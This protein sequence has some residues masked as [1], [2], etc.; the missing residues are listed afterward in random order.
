MTNS[1][2]VVCVISL[3]SPG[4]RLDN[5]KKLIKQLVSKKLDVVV[6]LQNYPYEILEDID[7]G[8]IKILTAEAK[9][10]AHARN[11]FL[12]EYYNSEYEYF[13]F[14][15]DDIRLDSKLKAKEQDTI[16]YLI[17]NIKTSAQNIAAIALEENNFVYRHLKSPND[18]HRL[19]FWAS[20]FILKNLNKSED[21]KLYFDEQYSSLEERQF[22][23]DLYKRGF[24]VKWMFGSSF[25]QMLNHS[26]YGTHDN[27][28]KIFEKNRILLYNNNKDIFKI[29][30]DNRLMYADSVKEDLKNA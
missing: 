7:D 2:V 19:D 15:D 14:C 11:R 21:F 4:K 18:I 22:A 3:Y 5:F 6:V 10:P 28:E 8:T 12:R 1:D 24:F 23:I 17:E 20:C 25:L 29:T 27:R 16:K 13:I 30:K 9:N 26:T